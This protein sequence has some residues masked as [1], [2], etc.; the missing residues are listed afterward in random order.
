MHKD[1]GGSVSDW[2]LLLARA[3]G[4]RQVLL[5]WLAHQAQGEGYSLPALARVL[6]VSRAYL[7][8]LY[9][10]KRD[11]A[12]I[13]EEVI[14]SLARFLGQTPIVVRCAAGEIHLS[15]FFTAQGLKEACDVIQGR[16][17]ELTVWCEQAPVVAVFA[18]NLAGL[19]LISR[20]MLRNLMAAGPG[21]MHTLPI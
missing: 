13:D 15:D 5:T 11:M 1:G 21:S 14:A 16:F 7:Y 3:Q 2:P 17:P 4:R 10:D 6:G 20:K 18:A 19:H 8:A 9:A 12:G